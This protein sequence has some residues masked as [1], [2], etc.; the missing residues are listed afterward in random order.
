MKRTARWVIILCSSILF[1]DAYA[2]N[3]ED[4]SVMEVN[5]GFLDFFR[6]KALIHRATF[7]GWLERAF[8]LEDIPE[9]SIEVLH[10]ARGDRLIVSFKDLSRGIVRCRLI[11]YFGDEDSTGKRNGSFVLNNC[12]IEMDGTFHGYVQEAGIDRE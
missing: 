4:D 12:S 8:N 11:I 7:A 2:T 10:Q 5:A 1:L 6:N 3:S 9:E